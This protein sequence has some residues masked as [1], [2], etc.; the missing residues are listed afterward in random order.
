MPHVHYE[1]EHPK[2][3]SDTC[4]G[5]DQPEGFH[6]FAQIVEICDPDLR[7]PRPAVPTSDGNEELVSH[8]GRGMMAEAPSSCSSCCVGI[9]RFDGEAVACESEDAGPKSAGGVLAPFNEEDAITGTVAEVRTRHFA[10]VHSFDFA[11][12]EFR[13]RCV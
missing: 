3:Q 2:V 6:P 4:L 9:G 10:L 8:D 11:T 13:S 5:L 1:L 7:R 12:L